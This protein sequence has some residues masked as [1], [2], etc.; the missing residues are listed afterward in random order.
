MTNRWDEFRKMIDEVAA[1]LE[2]RTID[3]EKLEGVG[4]S[5]RFNTLM[6]DAMEFAY[7]RGVKDALD[8]FANFPRPSQKPISLQPMS[9][10]TR[11][12]VALAESS[13]SSEEDCDM[14]TI[15]LGHSM[16][17]ILKKNH[18]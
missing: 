7:R 6:E 5:G 13:L 17:C 1:A 8:S 3:G 15:L 11:K 2:V 14:T 18:K 12:F 9:E 10:E 16:K 4:V